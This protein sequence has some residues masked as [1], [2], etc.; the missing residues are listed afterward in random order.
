MTDRYQDAKILRERQ[1]AAEQ[2]KKALRLAEKRLNATEAEKQF[3][4]GITSGV[5]T[6]RDIPQTMN[7][8][9]VMWLA[10]D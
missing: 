10:D 7:A 3:A 8:D 2:A 5:Y 1:A 6:E 9:K 4:A